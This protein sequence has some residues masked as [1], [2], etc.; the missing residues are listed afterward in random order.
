[1]ALHMD[2][3]SSNP[4]LQPASSAPVPLPSPTP[5]PDRETKRA[6]RLEAQHSVLKAQMEDLQLELQTATVQKAQLEQELSQL[7]ITPGM[8]VTEL[9][10]LHQRLLDRANQVF[11]HMQIL[12]HKKSLKEDHGIYLCKICMD[13]EVSIMLRPCSHAVLCTA[14]APKFSECPICR[15]PI[16][17][18][19][20]FIMG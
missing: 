4:W 14:C 3:D 12:L 1:M 6:K 17:K 7:M 16:M 5:T 18:R 20:N 13:G 8:D 11:S 10:L 9:G 19:V 15:K 2:G